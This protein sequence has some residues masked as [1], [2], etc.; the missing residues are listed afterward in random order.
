MWKPLITVRKAFVYFKVKKNWLGC[1][2][3]AWYNRERQQRVLKCLLS[4]WE[5]RSLS[6]PSWWDSVHWQLTFLYCFLSASPGEGEVASLYEATGDVHTLLMQRN[7]SLLMQRNPS[8]LM[9]RNPSLYLH[10]HCRAINIF[11]SHNLLPSDLVAQSV[12]QR[13]SNPKVVGLNPTLVRVFLCP[14]VGPF[15]SVGL[16]LTWYMGWNIS[17]SHHILSL[18]SFLI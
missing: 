10:I 12:E 7:P 5:A 14:C 13:W 17:T 18:Y 1:I 2:V 15:P 9:Q 4:S 16:T 11:I 8:L 6:K 3:L